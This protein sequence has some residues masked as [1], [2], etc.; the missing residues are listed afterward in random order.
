[1][2]TEKGLG[3][4]HRASGH[5]EQPSTAPMHIEIL[6]TG[7]ESVRST[8]YWLTKRTSTVLKSNSSKKGRAEKPSLAGC[9]PASSYQVMH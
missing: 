2:A 6:Q 9:I 7:E 1:M 4:W 8:T 3:I 5:S